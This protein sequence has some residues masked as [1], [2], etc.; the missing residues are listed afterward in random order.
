VT[1]VDEDRL[2]PWLYR[3]RHVLRVFY[4]AL[5]LAASKL[6]ILAPS[7]LPL[8]GITV[9]VGLGIAAGVWVRKTSTATVLTKDQRE[10]LAELG[11]DAQRW[12]ERLTSP[13]A[14]A[15]AAI[16]C[17]AGWW[18]R[19]D[20]LLPASIALAVSAGVVAGVRAWRFRIRPQPV[21]A[22]GV[23]PFGPRE[24][25]IAHVALG[26][27]FL[28][29]AVVTGP[30]D[31]INPKGDRIG[32]SLT[33]DLPQGSPAAAKFSA[34]VK[35]RTATTFG[36]G[37]NLDVLITLDPRNAARF[38]VTVLDVPG[39]SALDHVHRYE[40]ST[41]D[42]ATGSWQQAVRADWSPARLQAYDPKHGARHI[43]VSG[44]TGGGKS[45]TL[46]RCCGTSPP[47]ASSSPSSSTSP[48]R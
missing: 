39:S 21:E 5:I 44:E 33:V 4:A 13:R 42:V 34:G 24:A 7:F 17:A 27:K 15:I 11:D 31:V 32:F 46:E 25:W 45:E 12:V 48:R 20:D 22:V 19:P 18:L 16:V 37:D 41:F 30:A 23:L 6:L 43:H 38:T 14:G 2:R 28:E 8:I 47:P 36:V 3:Y 40:G 35:D 1:V 29:R 10:N 9:A 26:D